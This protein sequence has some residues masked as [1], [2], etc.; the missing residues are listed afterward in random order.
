MPMRPFLVKAIDAAGKRHVFTQLART[1]AEAE[2]LAANKIGEFRRLFAR[3]P[4]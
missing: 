3:R 4:A 1:C 2:I